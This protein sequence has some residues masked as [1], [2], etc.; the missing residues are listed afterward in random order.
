MNILVSGS[1]GLIGSG[2]L[3]FLT[4]GGHRVTP[5]VRSKAEAG[6]TEVHWDPGNGTVDTGG[7]EGMDAVVHLAGENIASGRWTAERKRRIRESRVKGTGLLADSL[8]R[9]KQPPK[10]FVCASAIGYYGNRPEETVN[11]ESSSGS[12]FLP[13]V[14]REWEEVTK[15]AQESGIRVVRTR[16]G[17][18]LSPSGGALAKMLFPFR[19]GAGGNIGSGRQYMS[20]ISLDDTIGAIYHALVTENLQGA[21]NVVAP[22]PVTN[23]EFTR[24]LG[25]VLKRPTLFPMPA[26][27]ARLLLGEMAEE[28][29]L[30]SIRVEPVRLLATGYKF[31]HPELEG[32]LRRLLGK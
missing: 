25:Q 28:L 29:L 12:G 10:V 3:S 2:L 15:P 20:W 30:A 4:T 5:L 22:H 23:S 19:M 27:A 32:A 7:L 17:I 1:G 14:C 21:V 26:F 16:F 13:D 8:A 9:L 31:R 18:I 24:T 11:E 6:S